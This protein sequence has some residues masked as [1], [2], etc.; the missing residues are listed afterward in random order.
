V[1]DDGMVVALIRDVHGVHKTHRPLIPAPKERV[2]GWSWSLDREL[3]VRVRLD[4]PKIGI[5]P[6]PKTERIKKMKN[7]ELSE[8]V[9]QLLAFSAVI[10]AFLPFL[11]GDQLILI[12]HSLMNEGGVMFDQFS[13]YLVGLLS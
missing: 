9:S 11:L 4:G 8:P 12:A 5:L 1:L 6:Q 3:E 13:T 2:N 10:V 7:L